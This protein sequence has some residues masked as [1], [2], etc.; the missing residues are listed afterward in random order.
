[1]PSKIAVLLTRRSRRCLSSAHPW[2]P[3]LSEPYRG[4]VAWPSGET[5][6]ILVTLFHDNKSQYYEGKDWN[7]VIEEVSKKNDQIFR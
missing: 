6:E 7:L 1:L 2:E 5:Q 4:K 3:S